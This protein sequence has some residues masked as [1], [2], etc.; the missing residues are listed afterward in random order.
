MTEIVKKKPLQ[1]P[2]SIKSCAIAI[3]VKTPGLTPLKTRL[4]KSIGT[5]KAHSFYRASLKCIEE[6]LSLLDSN[7]F[8]PHWAVTEKE[9]LCNPIW[10]GFPTLLQTRGG[11]GARLHH[12]YSFLIQ[13]YDFVLMIGA[14]SPQLRTQH[15]IQAHKELLNFDFVMGPA[16]DGGFYLFGGKKHISESLWLSTA[17]SQPST[18]KALAHSL[19]G[20]GELTFLSQLFDVDTLKELQQLASIDPQFQVFL[21]SQDSQEP[22]E[23]PKKKEPKGAKMLEMNPSQKFS[24]PDVT[25]KGEARAWVAP[26][27]LQTLW[28]NT[29]TLCNLTCHHCYIESS[30]KNDR[31]SYI[32]TEEVQVFLDEIHQEKMGTQEIGF[33]GGEPFMNPHIIDTLKLSLSRGFQ[34]LVL[35]NGMKPMMKKSEELLGLCQTYGSSL[36]IRVSIGS[37][38]KRKTYPRKGHEILGAHHPRTPVAFK[39]WF[40]AHCGWTHPLG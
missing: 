22:K 39:I 16:N 14:D 28:F 37:L 17:Y 29:G 13:S 21:P 40:S 30:P 24:H 15:Y 27:Q 8:F 33:T 9:G 10:E 5:D 31:L 2:V 4:A 11:L 32:T 26:T 7:I 3:F 23:P 36:K 6:Q 35:T 25:A 1:G 38:S 20:I 18:A 19:Q 34:V 12:I